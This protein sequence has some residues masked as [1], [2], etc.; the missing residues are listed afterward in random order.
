VYYNRIQEVEAGPAREALVN[1]LR[2]QY[3][4]D[5]DLHKLASEL[6]VDEVLSFGELRSALVRRF[7]LYADKAPRR[8]SKKH[9]ISPM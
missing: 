5:V 2:E 1:E 6:V 4:R 7:A 8:P 9:L 3:R